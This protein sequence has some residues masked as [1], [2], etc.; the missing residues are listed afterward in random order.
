MASDIDKVTQEMSGADSR[1]QVMDWWSA[2]GAGLI[3]GTLTLLIVLIA[4]PALTGG[5]PANV[6]RFIAGIVLGSDVIPPPTTFS[7]T[8]VVMGT[9]VHMALSVIYGVVLALIIHRW[10]IVVGVVGGVLF[11][12]ALFLINLFSFAKWFEWFYALRSWPFLLLHIFYGAAAGGLYELLE[13]DRHTED[14]IDRYV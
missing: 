14:E 1:H 6:F 7:L 11:G 4:Y 13:R 3:A 9:I 8:A 10:G 12:L 5:S 2:V